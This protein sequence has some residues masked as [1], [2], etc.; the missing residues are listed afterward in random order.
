M[1]DA[2]IQGEWD[3]TDI[4]LAETWAERMPQLAKVFLSYL[5]SVDVLLQR[6]MAEPAYKYPLR[7]PLLI[8]GDSGNWTVVN[9]LHPYGV[10]S[11][12]GYPDT[13]PQPHPFDDGRNSPGYRKMVEGWNRGPG[14]KGVKELALNEG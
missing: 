11:G 9:S 10:E 5:W 14:L 1:S 8:K 3:G 7:Q 13:F 2:F 12:I 4:A 6:G